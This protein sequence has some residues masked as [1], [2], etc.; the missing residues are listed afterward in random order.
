MR[1]TL[2][3]NYLIAITGIACVILGQFLIENC[4]NLGVYLA[5]KHEFLSLCFTGRHCDTF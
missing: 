2:Y 1:S 3:L 5:Q 4:D